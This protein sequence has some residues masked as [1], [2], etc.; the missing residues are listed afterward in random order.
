[1]K[2]KSLIMILILA[3]ILKNKTLIDSF[4]GTMNH[5]PSMEIINII[6]PNNFAFKYI[7][8]VKIISINCWNVF[9]N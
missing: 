4:T 5:N 3:L 8:F 1:M 6:K 2:Y 9:L 7:S